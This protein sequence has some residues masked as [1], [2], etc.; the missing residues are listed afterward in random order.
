M[1]R[2]IAHLLMLHARVLEAYINFA[3]IYMKYHILPVLP[4][5]DPI[6]GDGNP[7]S[8]FKLATGTKPPVSHSH[9]LFCTC[10]VQKATANAGT[11]ELNMRH[12]E[13]KGFHG[14][15]FGIP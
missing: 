9:V 15:F 8:P 6:N 12:Q 11:K 7:T 14:I 2:T 10:V 5:K 3:L 13:Q 1:L 4:I